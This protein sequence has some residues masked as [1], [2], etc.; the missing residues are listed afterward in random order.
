MD[1]LEGA[2]IAL[3]PWAVANMAFATRPGFHG[4]DGDISMQARRAGKRV[5]VLDID[6]HHHTTLGFD[7]QASHL[8]WLDADREFRQRWS[9]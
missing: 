1:L 4:Y 5:V 8:D 7:D 3:S 6:A 9:L 2:L